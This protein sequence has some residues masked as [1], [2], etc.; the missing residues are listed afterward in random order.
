MKKLISTFLIFF[1]LLFL[2]PKNS[3]SSY[4]KTDDGKEISIQTKKTGLLLKKH[5]DKLERQINFYKNKLDL[6]NDK[7][8]IWWLEDIKVINKWLEAIKNDKV[9]ALKAN[10]L[11][12]SIINRLK[13]INRELKPYLKEKLIENQK[14]IKNIKYKYNP[15]IKKFNLKLQRWI[16]K[17][18]K[19]IN[20]KNIPTAKK[21]IIKK[22]LDNIENYILRLNTFWRKEFYSIKELKEFLII[23][24]KWIIN[25][26][27]WLK[28]EL[29]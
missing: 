27:N 9:W 18:E 17:I 23:N 21:E 20:N 16:N 6:N 14:K 5:V 11:I 2:I 8:I 12:K 26:I 13:T 7:K 10:I 28:K 25:E 19:K 22:H 4:Y 1:S 24:I 3:F 29:S 15:I